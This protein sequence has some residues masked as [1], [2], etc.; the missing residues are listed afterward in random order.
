MRIGQC[1]LGKLYV[2]EI[3]TKRTVKPYG[4]CNLF[5]SIWVEYFLGGVQPVQVHDMYGES[6][7]SAVVGPSP[8]THHL[9]EF[10]KLPLVMRC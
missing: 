9:H 1:E 3:P 8:C 6:G 7:S 10:P 4:L 2:C 5:R